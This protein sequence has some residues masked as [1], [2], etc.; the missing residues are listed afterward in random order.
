MSAAPLAL[1]VSL[2]F[3]QSA[4]LTAGNGLR[5]GAVVALATLAQVAAVTMR[6]GGLQVRLG[7]GEAAL[8]IALYLVPSGWVPLAICVGVILARLLDRVFGP[9]R[10]W[11]DDAVN[12]GM[13]TVTA[14]AAAG[15]ACLI[16]DP[17]GAPV[18]TRTAAALLGGAL[19]Y[20][21]VGGALVAIRVSARAGVGYLPA[22]RGVLAG[23]AFMLIGNVTVG[24][25]AVAV[26]GA[27]MTWFLVLTPL[28]W[29]LRVTYRGRLVASDDRD[30]WRAFVDAQRSLTQPDV[31]GVVDAGLAGV[32][33]VF[34]ADRAAIRITTPDG[35]REYA[36]GAEADPG[37]PVRQPLLVGGEPVGEVELTRVEPL[38]EQEQSQFL[39]LAGNIAVALHDA[40]SQRELATLAERRSYDAVHDPLTGIA[41]RPGFLDA[42]EARLRTLPAD[43]RVALLLLDVNRFKQV[44]ETLGHSG[45]DDVLREV[46]KRIKASV[47]AADPVARLGDDEFA[48]LITVPEG[49]GDGSP[50]AIDRARELGELIAYPIDAAGS[51]VVAEISV[52][53]VVARAGEC[54]L[55]E[56]LRRADVALD[57]ARRAGSA[58]AWYDPDNDTVSTDRLVLLAELREALD[59][60]D[61]L[62]LMLQPAVD[63]DSGGPV[64]MEA[65]IRWAHPRR[66]ELHPKDFVRA[67][68]QSELIGRFTR[69]VLERALRIAGQWRADGMPI[70]ISVN[71]SPRNLLDPNLPNDVARL[72]TRYQ[73]PSDL[74]TLEIIETVVVPDQPV[75]MEVLEGL[76]ALGVRLSV[77]DFG[78]GYSSLAFLTQVRVDE[79]KVDRKFVARMADSP[80]AAAIVRATLDIAHDLDLRVVAEGVETVEQ[81]DEL[82]ALGCVAAQGFHFFRPMLPDSAKDAVAA[83]LGSARVLPFRAEEAS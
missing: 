28:L 12:V 3:W 8:I 69:Y 26:L 59:V 33:R 31:A 24:M 80:E 9:G 51:P 23:K 83:L 63:L 61:Q 81:K 11:W 43:A 55:T 76:R 77:D 13:L 79:V 22:V 10:P 32:L 75:V 67:V 29:V 78:T 64:G 57:R 50:E 48:L 71:L 53:V 38:T 16:R 49:E 36:H 1:A 58:V 52:G 30:S 46:A 56:L 25:I 44:N 35:T 15:V 4:E 74:L 40:D 20:Y 73:V 2:L 65:L 37:E 54:G 66:G 14:T 70:P 45:G 6:S 62:V 42:G 72:L 82:R 47:E 34:H 21:V 41:N 5:F 19:V 60:D 39:I 7:W 17:A 68:E 18:T 27:H